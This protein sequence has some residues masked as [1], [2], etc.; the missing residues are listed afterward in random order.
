MD[1]ERI[2]YILEQNGIT[3]IKEIVTNENYFVVKFCYEFDNDEIKAA[4]A[5][6]NEESQE[7]EGSTDWYNDWYLPYLYDIAKDNIQEV[8]EEICDEFDI[9]GE[10]KEIEAQNLDVDY[11]EGI[12]IFCKDS[13]EIDLEDILNDNLEY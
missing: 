2:I 12:A 8:I 6:S 13:S 1:S 11:M 5:Y 9:E 3:E 10:F 4:K 7:E